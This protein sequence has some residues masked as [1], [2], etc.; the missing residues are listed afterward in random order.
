MD[1]EHLGV[2]PVGHQPV[3]HSVHQMGFSQADATV[4]EQRVVQVSR[5]AGHVHRSSACHAVGSS[6]DQRVKGEARI[7]P[8]LEGRIGLVLAMTRDFARHVGFGHHAHGRHAHCRL[9]RCQ[10]QLDNHG[11][12]IQLFCEGSD[13]AGVLGANP[14]ELEPVGDK[15]RDA[16]QIVCDLGGQGFDPGVELLLGQVLRQLVDTGLPEALAYA[17]IGHES[18][19]SKSVRGPFF[20]SYDCG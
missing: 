2:G 18:G 10:C 16:R 14:I 8:V 12:A 9:A 19:F 5:H 17:I 15:D 20:C 4:D 3:A 6:F 1:V 7:E 11:L 13:L